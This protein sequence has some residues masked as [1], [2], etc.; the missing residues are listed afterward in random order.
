MTKLL[1]ATIERI[2]P[3]DREMEDQ[4]QVRLDNK[5]KPPGSLGR[6]EEV[7]RRIVGI[8]RKEDPPRDK[9]IVVTMAGD[10]GVAAEGIS[11]FP[12]ETTIQMMA[13]FVGGGAGV[14]VLAR[15]VGA[16]NV[17]VD[18]GVAGDLTHLDGVLHEKIGLGTGNIA[19]EPAMTR[20]QAVQSV[21]TGIRIVADLVRDGRVDI[22]GTG[23]M[24]IANTSPSAAIVACFTGLP[25]Q[26][27]TGR[28]T[29]IDDEAWKRKVSAIER[30]LEVNRPDPKDPI[31]V[32]SKVGGFEIG[33]LGGLVLG[34]A[35]NRIPVVV[36]G[37][38]A[39]AGALV[40]CELCP[41]ARQYV[42]ASHRSV[43][44]GHRAMLE[45][46]G[47][48]PLLDLSLRLGE[49]TGAA[50]AIGILDAG[51]KILTEMASFEAASVSRPSLS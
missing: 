22:L 42:F 43:E 5:T 12:Q 27:V 33:G 17:V 40:V 50:L 41:T 15:H 21:E 26:E 23:D 2:Q 35:A 38:I 49:G 47:Q 32:L 36:D 34:A 39:T 25:P 28:G 44:T 30:A 51:I 1:D 3:V 19:K 20:E 18:M 14:N 29:G 7:A 6:L 13:N 48:V 9:K 31:D 37:F 45:R 16:A 4:A 8:T 10:H 11:R 24:G 46:I